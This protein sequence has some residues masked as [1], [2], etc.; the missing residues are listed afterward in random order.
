VLLDLLRISQRLSLQL[1]PGEPRSKYQA[2]R[3]TGVSE[4]TGAVRAAMPNDLCD[5][6]RVISLA[7]TRSR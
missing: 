3:R 7:R 5:V 2:C 6:W 1:L 4:I